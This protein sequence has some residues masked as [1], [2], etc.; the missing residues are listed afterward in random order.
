MIVA[1]DLSKCT[2]VKDVANHGPIESPYLEDLLRRLGAPDDV[3]LAKELAVERMRCGSNQT[4][5]DRVRVR[6]Q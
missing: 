4:A 6:R 2:T 3:E 5:Y 1:I